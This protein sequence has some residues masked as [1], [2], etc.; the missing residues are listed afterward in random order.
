VVIQLRDLL[1]LGFTGF[2]F[3]LSGPD[4]IANMQ[5]IAEDVFP[6]LRSTG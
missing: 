2:N 6:I 1:G 5:R 3:I 4:R